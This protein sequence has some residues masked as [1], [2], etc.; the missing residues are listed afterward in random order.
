[1]QVA[2]N[3]VSVTDVVEE[4]PLAPHHILMVVAIGHSWPPA[5][6]QMALLRSAASGWSADRND[7]WSEEV[8]G[9][10]HAVGLVGPWTPGAYSAVVI[11]PADGVKIEFLAVDTFRRHD[12][13]AATV[14]PASSAA[15][16]RSEPWR[17]AWPGMRTCAGIVRLG[18]IVADRS[19]VR[20]R[21]RA[22]DVI[23]PGLSGRRV[24][25]YL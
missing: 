6:F 15:G 18:P 17:G 20:I 16:W 21:R 1:V 2:P 13:C 23:Q 11:V 8:S 10:R 7:P 24:F 12:G 22:D 5:R 4:L 14:M 9:D 25:S 19:G 3:A